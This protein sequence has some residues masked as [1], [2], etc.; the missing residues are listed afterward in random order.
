MEDAYQARHLTSGPI[1]GRIVVCPDLGTG[2]DERRQGTI[3]LAM[4][5]F[6]RA[7]LQ[8]T[9]KAPG[10]EQYRRLR[11]TWPRAKAALSL[12]QV[13]VTYVGADE[14]LPRTLPADAVTWKKGAADG[15]LVRAEPDA[16]CV[17]DLGQAP[18]WPHGIDLSLRLKYLRLEPLWGKKTS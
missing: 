7:E 8:A 4:N 15:A 17:I 1:L 12:D 5:A 18:A 13:T 11:I 2:F 14:R 9:I 16:V 10:S 6:G 3:P